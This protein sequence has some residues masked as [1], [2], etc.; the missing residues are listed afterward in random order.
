MRSRL[1][2]RTA[3]GLCERLVFREFFAIGLTAFDRMELTV[4]G[5]R[6]SAT[7]LVARLEVRDLVEQIGLLP[8]SATDKPAGIA[9]TG[10]TGAE[11]L[12]D[13]PAAAVRPAKRRRRASIGKHQLTPE[14]GGPADYTK[15]S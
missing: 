8:R 3:R 6:P 10:S 14:P 13:T 12:T 7:N 5:A 4:L 15:V 9:V 11:V 1:G 2:F